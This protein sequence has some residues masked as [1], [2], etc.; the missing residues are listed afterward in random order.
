MTSGDY[1]RG[2]FIEPT[3]FTDVGDGMVIACEEI[4]GPVLP[5]FSFETE[6]EVI[7][8]ANNTTYGLAAGVWTRDLARAHRMGAALKA[9]VVWVNTYDMFDSAAP[10]GGFKGSVSQAYDAESGGAAQTH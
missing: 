3:I 6:E 5:V 7:S 9:G 1:A 4:F 10:F 8:R 2:L